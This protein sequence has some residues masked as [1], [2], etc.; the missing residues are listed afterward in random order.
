LEGK[1]DNFFIVCNCGCKA[2]KLSKLEFEGSE[3]LYLEYWSPC[4]YSN[5]GGV[6]SRF[7]ERLKMALKIMFKGDYF[8]HDILLGRDDVER[9][10]DYVN[11]FYK[12][13]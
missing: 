10:K 3:E 9:L 4:F 11:E 12:G 6:F 5:Q 13:V 8:L 7:F 1:E 2:L